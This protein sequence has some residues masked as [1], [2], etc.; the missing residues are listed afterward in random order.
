MVCSAQCRNWKPTD[1]S[2]TNGD[3]IFEYT[4]AILHR[5]IG[6]MVRHQAIRINDETENDDPLEGGHVRIL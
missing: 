5:G 2:M 4:R 1:Q 3:V 6:E